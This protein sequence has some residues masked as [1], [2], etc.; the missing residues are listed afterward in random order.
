MPPSK[1][2]LGSREFQNQIFGRS[3]VASFKTEK[4]LRLHEGLAGIVASHEQMC[5]MENLRVWYEDETGGYLVLIHFSGLFRKG[6]MKFYLNDVN[7][8]INVKDE[9]HRFLRVKGL[10]IP[11]M[12]GSKDKGA[13]RNITGA[14]IEFTTEAEKAAFLALVRE[15]Q[16]GMVDMEES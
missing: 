4:T 13:R 1:H 15:A 8:P 10:R 2:P 3:L 5:A 12:P 7:C 6:Y 14:K 9:A 11:M 16:E